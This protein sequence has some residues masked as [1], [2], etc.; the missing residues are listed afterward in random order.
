[1]T[2]QRKTGRMA[3]F[4]FDAGS[5][6]SDTSGLSMTHV[7][8]YTRLVGLYWTSGNKLPSDQ[9]I[10]KRKIGITTDEEAE[11]LSQVLEEFFPDG[12]NLDLDDQL[13]E[14]ATISQKAS[15]SRRI[16]IE[17]AKQ[18]KAPTQ[19]TDGGDF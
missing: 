6:M 7:G 4:K 12:T 5:F 9:N 10:M 19:P 15:E 18:T 17:K 11:A 2:S 13:A 14:A 3:W 16:G 1:V 8:I